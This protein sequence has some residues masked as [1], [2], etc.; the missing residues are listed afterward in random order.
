MFLTN[1]NKNILHL[2]GKLPKGINNDVL[3]TRKYTTHIY[4]YNNV[5][6]LNFN[7]Y[8]IDSKKIILII[9]NLNFPNTNNI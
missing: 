9:F 5:K 6:F 4:I 8:W 1:N 2:F 7:K 3:K